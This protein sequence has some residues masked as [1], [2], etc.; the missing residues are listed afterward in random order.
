MSWIETDSENYAYYRPLH[1][2]I[3]FLDDIDR[4]SAFLRDNCESV[5]LHAG[6]AIADEADDL[7]SASRKERQDIQIVA[8]RPNITVRLSSVGT[9]VATRDFTKKSRGIVDDVYTLLSERKTPI[10]MPWKMA[11]IL[12]FMILYWVVAGKIVMSA[13]VLSAVYGPIF[14]TALALAIT[15]FMALFLYRRGRT[16]LVTRWRRDLILLGHELQKG[17]V[18]ALL[19]A[20][21]GGAVTALLTILSLKE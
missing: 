17:S 2:L 16:W 21:L 12:L 14:Y 18:L 15:V 1:F 19:S 10:L 13:G 4:I 9:Y 6:T 8:K 3:V 11:A 5:T 7:L 20:L